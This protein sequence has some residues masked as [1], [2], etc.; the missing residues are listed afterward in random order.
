M[1]ELEYDEINVKKIRTFYNGLILEDCA[2]SCLSWCWKSWRYGG[3]F[4][5][6]EGFVDGGMLTFNNEELYHK[7]NQGCLGLELKALEGF[8]IKIVEAIRKD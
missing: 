8:E 5:I 2:H 4:K 1:P 6:T 3:L 7:L